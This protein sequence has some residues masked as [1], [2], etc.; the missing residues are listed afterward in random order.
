MDRV[1]SVT[2]AEARATA[3]GY[4]MVGRVVSVRAPDAVAG[5]RPAEPNRPVVRCSG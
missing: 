2:D 4:D 5:V 3:Y 1:T